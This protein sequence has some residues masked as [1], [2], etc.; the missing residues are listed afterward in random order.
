MVGFV[1]LR[2]DK[3]AQSG[4]PDNANGNTYRTF[5]RAALRGAAARSASRSTS[6]SDDAA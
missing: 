5:S 4:R 1:A 2:Q 6:Y 3:P